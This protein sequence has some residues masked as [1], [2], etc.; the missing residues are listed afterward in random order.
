LITYYYY[1]FLMR[2]AR[3]P[4]KTGEAVIK[5]DQVP[6]K[7]SETVMRLY[8]TETPTSQR[9]LG[10]ATELATKTFDYLKSNNIKV[11]PTC[12]FLKKFLRDHPEY[13]SVVTT[14]RDTSFGEW[15]LESAPARGRLVH[16]RMFATKIDTSM[17]QQPPPPSSSRSSSRGSG[18]EPAD[19]ASD[20]R[21]TNDPARQSPLP[22][23]PNDTARIMGES[24]SQMGP[25]GVSSTAQSSMPA[26]RGAVGQSPMAAAAAADSSKPR[27]TSAR[28][29][30]KMGGSPMS[31]LERDRVATGTGESQSRAYASRSDAHTVDGQ[32]GMRQPGRNQSMRDETRPRS[33][34]AGAESSNTSTPERQRKARETGK[35][36]PAT[37]D[38][39]GQ[40]RLKSKE[41]QGN[42]EQPQ[43]GVPSGGGKVGSTVSASG[44]GTFAFQEAANPL[45]M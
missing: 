42:R 19:I 4:E 24:P 25:S 5:Y 30:G 13:T 9:R 26:Q 10:V 32:F 17:S 18:R 11:V 39:V 31:S 27:S 36:A 28:T 43:A 41:Q 38:D 2:F 29:L 8:H 37:I 3:F 20:R 7:I 16:A 44:G 6:G 35:N 23:T 14:A 33:M 34:R 12:G 1:Y 40:S 15:T 45:T 22:K 21:H